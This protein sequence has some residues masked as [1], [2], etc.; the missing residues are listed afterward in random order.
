MKK[1]EKEVD[2]SEK[3]VKTLQQAMPVAV[4]LRHEDIITAGIP[5]ISVSLGYRTVWLETKVG[6]WKT[7]GIQRHTLR[8]LKGFYVVFK[9]AGICLI[10]P[11][12]TKQTDKIHKVTS[13]LNIVFFVRRILTTY[14]Q[15]GY[16][17]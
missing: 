17:C 6:K 2:A 13:L 4:I 14:S 10:E 16:K 15:V 1:V 8:R 5:D 9:D 11:G 3:L 7:T 12:R